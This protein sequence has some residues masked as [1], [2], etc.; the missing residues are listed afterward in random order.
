MAKKIK[1]IIL[2]ILIASIGYGVWRF[3]QN[4]AQVYP[5]PYRLG[6][7]PE[8]EIQEAQAADILVVGDSAGTYLS[9]YLKQFIERTSEDLREPLKIYNW[10]REGETLA[11]VLKKVKSLKKTPSLILYHG[12]LDEMDQARFNV[13]ALP[14]ISKNIEMASK[15]GILTTVMS[16]PPLA[17]LIYWPHKRMSLRF[18]NQ[19]EKGLLSPFPS[20]LSPQKA[21]RVLETFYQ[22]YRW[23]ARELFS[24]LKL[25]DAKIWV[26]PQAYNLKVP[27]SRTCENSSNL[28]IEKILKEASNLIIKGHTKEAFSLINT[29]LEENKT[30]ARALY[31]MGNLMTKR[32]DFSSAKRA[33]YQAMIYDCALRRANPVM[34]KLLLEEAEKKD[35]PIINFNRLVTNHLG[36]NILFEDLRKPQSIYYDALIDTLVKEF[37]RFLRK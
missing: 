6:A 15:D 10:A 23:E 33:Y 27:P 9:P 5:F 2:L 8:S 28:E 1:G 4:P 36:K 14:T 32:G 17:R 20:D 30:H 12:G 35:F 22:V 3:F 24:T 26:I 31:T 25:K 11:H 18:F 37:R 13:N 21:L 19:E 7:I 29:I 34:L 16:F